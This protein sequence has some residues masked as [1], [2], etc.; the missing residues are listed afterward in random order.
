M[1][2]ANKVFNCK[3]RFKDK[4]RK[5]SLCKN[6][7]SQKMTYEPVSDEEISFVADELALDKYVVEIEKVA[8]D[9]EYIMDLDAIW[10]LNKNNEI[11]L[12]GMQIN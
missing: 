9:P 1:I 7:D 8:G 3:I 2:K 10:N 6:L 12:S 11:R 4:Q 5:D